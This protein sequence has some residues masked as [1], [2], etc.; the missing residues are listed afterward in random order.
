MRHWS[1]TSKKSGYVINSF[2]VAWLTHKPEY[3][4]NTVNSGP[5]QISVEFRL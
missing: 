5:V 4:V 1:A 2:F 3:V